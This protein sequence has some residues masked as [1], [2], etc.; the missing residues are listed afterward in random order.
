M[1]NLHHT[2]FGQ[3]KI[4]PPLPHCE[5]YCKQLVP[6]CCLLSKLIEMNQVSK[7][8]GWGVG[9]GWADRNSPMNSLR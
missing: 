1:L 5:T 8:M 3:H 9:N 7:F 2:P 6:S 4:K